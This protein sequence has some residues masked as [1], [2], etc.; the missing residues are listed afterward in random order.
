[1]VIEKITLGGGCFWCI[2]TTLRRVKGVV[3]TVSGYSGGNV[4]NPTYEMVYFLFLVF[5]I[6]NISHFVINL[7]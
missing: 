4:E 5:F 1:M 6:L 3:N 7:R 2:E